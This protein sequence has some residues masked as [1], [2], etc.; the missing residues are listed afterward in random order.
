L[1]QGLF[2]LGV[3]IP[4]KDQ[5]GIGGAM[6]PSVLL[7]FLLELPGSP[8]CIAEREN[9]A[10]R[11]IAARDRL[12]NVECCRQADAFIYRQRGILDKEIRRVE[13]KPTSGFDRSALE[14]LHVFS[15]VRQL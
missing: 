5:F 15:A 2:I 4:A 10:G 1:A 3:G 11:S 8:P 13:D 7:D 12:E 14:H 9:G 6:Q